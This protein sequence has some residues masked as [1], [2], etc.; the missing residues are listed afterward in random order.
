MVA[1]CSIFTLSFPPASIVIGKL[2]T[3]LKPSDIN[4]IS[5]I[6]KGD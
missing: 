5:S 4:V 2:P 6:I 1:R 3:T